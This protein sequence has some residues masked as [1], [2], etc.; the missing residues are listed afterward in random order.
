MARS[1]PK[2]CPFLVTVDL[3][4]KWPELP[5]GPNYPTLPYY[6]FILAYTEENCLGSIIILLL[7]SCSDA[8]SA[9]HRVS[10]DASLGPRPNHPSTDHFSITG[11][12]RMETCTYA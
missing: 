12:G 11:D 7:F 1:L 4:L 5:R 2:V 3:K 6:A 10:A 9:L 8:S